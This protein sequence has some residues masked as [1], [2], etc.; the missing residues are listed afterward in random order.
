[1]ALASW[2]LHPVHIVNND[3]RGAAHETLSARKVAF[4]LNKEEARFPSRDGTLRPFRA[5]DVLRIVKNPI[6]TGMVGWGRNIKS[7]LLNG[8]ELVEYH[9]PELQII[10]FEKFNRVQE[11]ARRRHWL[12]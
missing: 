12:G 11:I 4:S 7:R 1:M 5:A 2:E 8:L 3:D 10:S 6:Y 9:V